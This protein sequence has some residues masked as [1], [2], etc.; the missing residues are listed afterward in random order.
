MKWKKL[1]GSVQVSKELRGQT[2]RE[3]SLKFNIRAATMHKI[4]TGNLKMDR[5]F[6]L[7]PILFL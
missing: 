7:I 5:V 1:N 3:I 4:L 2:V 6:S